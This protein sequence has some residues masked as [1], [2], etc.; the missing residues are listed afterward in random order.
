MI[1]VVKVLI[2]N[3]VKQTSVD[4]ILQEFQNDVSFEIFERLFFLQFVQEIH[5]KMLYLR[6]KSIAFFNGIAFKKLRIFEKCT[7]FFLFSRNLQKVYIFLA[8]FPKK[9]PDKNYKWGWK[10]V[11]SWMKLQKKQLCR[12]SVGIFWPEFLS[13]FS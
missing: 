2:K 6:Y 4:I 9:S 1:L 5:L 7:Y 12:T 3:F 8:V 10:S 11:I 13:I